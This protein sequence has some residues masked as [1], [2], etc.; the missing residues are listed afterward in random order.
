MSGGAEGVSNWVKEA[1]TC[2]AKI[3]T[4]KFAHIPT[5]ANICYNAT[6]LAEHILIFVEKLS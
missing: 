5:K 6:P 4:A 2:R 1:G 3:F